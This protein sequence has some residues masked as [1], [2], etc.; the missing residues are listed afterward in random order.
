MQMEEFKQQVVKEVSKMKKDILEEFKTLAKDHL[1]TSIV[2]EQQ[3]KDTIQNST[4][5]SA[6]TVIK[7]IEKERR[8]TQELEEKSAEHERLIRRSVEEEKRKNKQV[9]E[10]MEKKM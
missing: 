8:L 4:K 5:D 3:L 2:E 10:R 9:V 6:Q 1:R 7:W